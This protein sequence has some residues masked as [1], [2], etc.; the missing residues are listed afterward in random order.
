MCG[1]YAGVSQGAQLKWVPFVPIK[2]ETHG[3]WRGAE[4][5][6]SWCQRPP[7]TWDPRTDITF[8]LPAK[9]DSL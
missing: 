4:A 3:E 8:V 7:R 2:M 6:S 5:S 9:S 1:E